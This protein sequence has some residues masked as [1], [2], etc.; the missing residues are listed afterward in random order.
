MLFSSWFR[1]LMDIAP[2]LVGLLCFDLSF[3]GQMYI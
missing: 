3:A 1:L 2:G